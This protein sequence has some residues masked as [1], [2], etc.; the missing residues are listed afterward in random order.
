MRPIRLAAALLVPLVLIAQDVKRPLLSSHDRVD[1]PFGG[2]YHVE[3]VQIFADGKVVYVE[4][5][6]RTLGA[7]S[8]RSTFEVT[9]G[10]DEMRRLAA[11]LDSR[12]IRSLPKNISSKTRPIDFFWQKSLQINRPDKTQ[13]IQIE[14][15]Y[16]FL[17]VHHGV[18]AKGLIE[19]ECSL[20]DVKL[21]AAKRPH[22]KDE[23][24]WCG[25]IRAKSGLAKVDCRDDATQPRIVAGEG[26]GAVRVGAALQAVDEV[27]GNGQSENRYSDVYFKE[28]VAKGVQ[29]SFENGSNKV[30]AIYFYNGQRNGEEI[31]IFCGRTDKG[32]NWQ[33]SPDEVKKAYGHPTA[34][35]SGADSVATWQ[36][37][38]FA[39][40]D[41]RF[42]NRKLV[43]IG[44]PGD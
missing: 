41:F 12:E 5:G 8:E 15:F 40:I 20:Q 28:Y 36:R 21:E 24:D 29:V 2:E 26:W 25:A 33:S 9:I 4:E 7:K 32:I 13:E 22:P 17:N 10:S 14:N 42:E 34:E 23:D 6:T 27:L 19:L 43:R 3:D 39:G 30:H 37:L 31:G 38:V 44:I 1:G 18:Y 16:P 35:Y 11:L